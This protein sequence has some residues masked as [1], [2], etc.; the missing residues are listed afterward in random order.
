MV[1]VFVPGFAAESVANWSLYVGFATPIPTEPF[2]VVIP[3]NDTTAVQITPVEPFPIHA[4]IY[5]PVAEMLT[6]C[7]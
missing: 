7:I 4:D 2:I 5:W 3:G 1:H 6:D